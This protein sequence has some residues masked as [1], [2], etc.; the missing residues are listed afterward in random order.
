VEFGE[1]GY[2]LD[3]IFDLIF[4]IFDVNYFDSHSLSGAFVY[5]VTN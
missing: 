3:D 5:T 4:G 1:N 2:F